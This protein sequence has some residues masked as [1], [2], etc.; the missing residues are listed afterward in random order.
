MLV[1]QHAHRPPLGGNDQ[2]G[3][4]IAIDVREDGARYQAQGGKGSGVERVERPAAGRGP[5]VQVRGS[6]QRPRSRYDAWSDKEIQPPVAVDIAEGERADTCRFWRRNHGR[7]T[8]LR[9]VSPERDNRGNRQRFGRRRR[10]VIRLAR[11]Q[12]K[13]AAL[14]RDRQNRREVPTCGWLRRWHGHEP[15]AGVA[16]HRDASTTTRADD[17]IFTTV[18]VDV[19]P[20][21]ARAQLTEPVRQQRL[22]AVIVE[23]RIDMR[24]AAEQRRGVFEE[25]R[26]GAG[27]VL[28]PGLIRQ[29]RCR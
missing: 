12:A 22:P 23:Q 20:A 1:V 14:N 6:G 19:N 18:T 9:S 28:C 10:L 3:P 21:H 5:Q 7:H 13:L 24:L 8:A 17:K 2:I 16:K 27:G 25:R 15:V 26:V 11:D 4:A 29:W